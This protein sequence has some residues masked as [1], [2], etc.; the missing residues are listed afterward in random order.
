[1]PVYLGKLQPLEYLLNKYQIGKTFA[2]KKKSKISSHFLMQMQLILR[3]IRNK[4]QF[5]YPL[6]FL[7]ASQPPTPTS[8]LSACFS[9]PLLPSQ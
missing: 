4:L 6:Y 7:W 2:L 5:K 9:F 3:N 1:M 8:C